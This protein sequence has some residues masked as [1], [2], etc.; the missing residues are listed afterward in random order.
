MARI[1]VIPNVQGVRYWVDGRRGEVGPSDD[2]NCDVEELSCSSDLV[3]S[4]VGRGLIDGGLLL[5]CCCRESWIC[6]RA[7]K[8]AEVCGNLLGS[9]YSS[10]EEPEKRRHRLDL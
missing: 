6:K 9:Y 10:S 7:R 3:V 1:W 4:P 8:L 2:F 5:C